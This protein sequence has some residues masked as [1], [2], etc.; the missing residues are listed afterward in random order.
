MGRPDLP[1]AIALNS[2]LFNST[3]VPGPAVGGVV[4]AVVAWPTLLSERRQ[5]S[6]VL[7]A[8]LLMRLPRRPRPPGNPSC[9][10]EGTAGLPLARRELRLVLL[11]MTLVAVFAMPY[12]VL[13]PMLAR[14]I[15]GVGPRG[16]G[17]LMAISGL[18]AF[19]GGLTLARR[20]QWPPPM[21]SFLRGMALFLP[22]QVA[23]G[24]R[25]NYYRPW[26][27]CSFRASAW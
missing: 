17:L 1:N 2:T 6:A 10:P 21:P 13:L 22:G 25:R 19:L 23:L 14:A 18:G 11:L 9:T 24:L 20:L 4:I 27:S 7:L 16:F 12:Y 8:L 3:R 15:L 26:S 5:F